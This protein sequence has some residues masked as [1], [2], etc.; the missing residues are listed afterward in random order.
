MK[1]TMNET[2]PSGWQR[3]T[4][5][6]LTSQCITLFGSTLV[7]MAVVWHAT[8]ETASGAWLQHLQCAPICPSFSSPF[9]EAYGRTGTAENC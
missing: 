8:M 9:Q 4:I 2:K 3:R 5:L 7:Q 1:Q 6:F